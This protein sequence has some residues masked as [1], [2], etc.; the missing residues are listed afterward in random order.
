M[1]YMSGSKSARNAA[2]IVNRTNTCGGNKKS[3]LAPTVGWFMSSNPMLIGAPQTIPRFCI[4]N[5]T[6][7]TQKYGYRATHGGNMG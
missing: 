1:V 6:I 7:Q 3:G 4:P 5:R 2:S